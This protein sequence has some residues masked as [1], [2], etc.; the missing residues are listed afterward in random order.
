MRQAQQPAR[1]LN[2]QPAFHDTIIIGNRFAIY[3]FI[4]LFSATGIFFK[5]VICSFVIKQQ[6]VV[7]T[8]IMIPMTVLELCLSIKLTR[9]EMNG[10]HHAT[11]LVLKK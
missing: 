2:Q 5:Q 3:Y 6:L 10:E 7:M 8:Q 4:Y 9:H 1:G 11:I